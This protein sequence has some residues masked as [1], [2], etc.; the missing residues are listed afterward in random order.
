MAAKSGIFDL[1]FKGGSKAVKEMSKGA[2]SAAKKAPSNV[3]VVP[4]AKSAAPKYGSSTQRYIEETGR[5]RI[6]NARPVPKKVAPVKKAVPS[7]SPLRGTTLSSRDVVGRIPKSVIA[8]ARKAEAANKA[9]YS[10]SL[11]KPLEMKK[12]APAK[13]VAPAKRTPAELAQM[14]RAEAAA[15]AARMQKLKAE[16]APVP[17]SGTIPVKKAQPGRVSPETARK[18][19]VMN[20][21]KTYTQR[22][23]AVRMLPAKPPVKKFR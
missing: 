16:R 14:G 2:G 9:A 7:Q 13:K 15:K 1:I 12:P 6:Y 11:A 23:D 18:L 5:P 21:N 8:K 3:R 4:P 10:K 22:R 17:A 20:K 19:A